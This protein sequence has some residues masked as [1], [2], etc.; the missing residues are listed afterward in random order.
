M[1]S[2][3]SVLNGIELGTYLYVN[4]LTLNSKFYLVVVKNVSSKRHSNFQGLFNTFSML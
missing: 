2:D 1:F 4:N 3:Q